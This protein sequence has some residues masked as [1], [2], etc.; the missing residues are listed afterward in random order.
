MDLIGWHSYRH[1]NVRL[2]VLSGSAFTDWIPLFINEQHA[3]VCV[4][5]FFP[6]A[7]VGCVQKHVN[8][9]VLF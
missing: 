7:S 2:G 1:E 9:Q 5:L 6:C 4:D 8:T 3:Q